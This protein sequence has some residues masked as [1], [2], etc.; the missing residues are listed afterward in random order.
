M[1]RRRLDDCNA[2]WTQLAGALSNVTAYQFYCQLND[3]KRRH[4]LTSVTLSLV[5]CRIRD[6]PA[7]LP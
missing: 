2:L 7:T 6:I 5:G 3:T 1:E 4:L